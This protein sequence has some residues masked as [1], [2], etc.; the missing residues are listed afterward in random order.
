M[1]DGSLRAGGGGLIDGL[2][3]DDLYLAPTGPT[4]VGE[5][6]LNDT[7]LSPQEVADGAAA[8]AAAMAEVR[9]AVAAAGGFAWQSFYNNG[10]NVD[11]LVRPGNCAAA[12]AA[13]CAADSPAQTRALLY[14]FNGSAHHAQFNSTWLEGWQADREFV[15]RCADCAR[16]G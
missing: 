4:E 5:G 16:A 8:Y 2:F 10:T 13:L 1:L 6:F 3:F 11:N 7:Q 9:A 14:G 12:L 15:A